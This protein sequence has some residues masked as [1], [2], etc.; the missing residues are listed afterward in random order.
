ML[1]ECY[2]YGSYPIKYSM[3]IIRRLKPNL[4]RIFCL[5]LCIILTVAVPFLAYRNADLTETENPMT[6]LHLWQ[7][8]SFEGGRGSRADYLQSIADDYSEN[9]YIT[10]T[11]ISADA[12]REN[13]KKGTVPDLISYGAA[14]YG[15]ESYIRHYE[16][17][18]YGSYCL[19]TL[20]EDSEFSDVRA[21]N[22]IINGG[23][24]NL[25]GAVAVLYKLTGAPIDRPTG[26]YVKLIQGKYKYLLGTQRDLFRLK[27]RGL[28]FSVKP[29]TVYNDLYQNISITTTDKKRSEIA[30]NFIK[31]LLSSQNFTNK[32]GLMCK[33]IKLYDDEMSILEELSYD[34][35]LSSPVSESYRNEL[36]S[37]I[38][39]ADINLIK[40]LLN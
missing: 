40:N 28:Q 9:N 16:C 38:S 30:E 12:A 13:L 21:D 5:I 10:V 20:E 27:M 8:D 14:T 6:V 19:L 31:F 23:I 1:P 7:I 29:I 32:I 34:Y 24:D 17:W 3:R 25:I 11:S 26:A 37:A 4:T 18:A 33:G 36:E 39:S 22:T 2:F 35:V 15:I